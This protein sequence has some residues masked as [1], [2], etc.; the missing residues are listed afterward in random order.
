MKSLTQKSPQNSTL[1]ASST[2]NL[3]V[4]PMSQSCVN[5]V[6]PST[7]RVSSTANI[8]ADPMSQICVNH[9]YLSLLLKL[10]QL[11]KET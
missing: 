2:G 10:Q 9:V 3:I 4:G 6:N 5:H 11:Q 8:I 7:P 1:R